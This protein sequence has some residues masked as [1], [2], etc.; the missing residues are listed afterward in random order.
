ML[1]PVGLPSLHSL[2]VF[3]QRPILADTIWEGK[4]T[5]KIPELSRYIN[6]VKEISA[7][8]V[9]LK[10]LPVEIW[11]P[12]ETT[13]SVIYVLNPP[14]ETQNGERVGRKYFWVIGECVPP[15][16]DTQATFFGQGLV[17]P[18][19]RTLVGTCGARIRYPAP[20]ATMNARYTYKKSKTNE[21]LTITGMASILY[22]RLDPKHRRY[23][24]DPRPSTVTYSGTFTKTP[25]LVSVARYQTGEN[26]FGVPDE[27]GPNDNLS[28]L[29]SKFLR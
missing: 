11:F 28:R 7:K 3:A 21:T 15:S 25:R 10:N 19:K 5:A 26:G 24:L 29:P 18:T 17:Y 12:T 23:L 6:G 4:L 14:Y 16:T 1:C 13:F 20:D 22:Q 27:Y 2:P 8:G 9:E